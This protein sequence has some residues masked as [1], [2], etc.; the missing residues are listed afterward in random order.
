[1]T[2]LVNSRP[3]DEKTENHDGGTKAPTYA[4]YFMVFLLGKV[5]E[6]DRK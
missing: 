4:K 2:V 3:G 5:I 6:S 1:M